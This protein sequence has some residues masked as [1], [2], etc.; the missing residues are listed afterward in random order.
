MLALALFTATALHP[1]RASHWQDIL[2]G[3]KVC[4]VDT[5]GAKGDGVT[6]DTAAIQSALNDCG[7]SGGGQVVLPASTGNGTY[8]S[9]ALSMNHS[10]VELNVPA[11]TVLR[12]SND[13]KHWPGSLNFITGHSAE[14]IAITGAGTI[15]GQGA[16]WW[17]N[18]ND[19][20]PHTVQFNHVTY[21][22][23]EGV[24]IVDP[25]NHCLELYAD[26]CEVSGV[27][28]QAPPSTG[29]AS[30]SHNTDAVDVHGDPFY[31]HDC[32][33][34]TGD[35]NIAA[36][37]NNTLVE[38]CRFGTGH[39]ASIGSLCDVW[40]TNITFRNISFDGTTSGA[41]IKVHDGCTRSSNTHY[42][43]SYNRP[44]QQGGRPA[45][46]SRATLTHTNRPLQQGGRPAAQSRATLT[47]TNR[48]LRHASRCT[49]AAR[50]ACGG[51]CSK[52]S[53]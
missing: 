7:G 34:N 4:S 25:P 39:G 24:T 8:L 46:Q 29:T 10:H 41:K 45:A 30:P 38:N 14:H 17:A 13:R 23:I 35:D 16:V 42:R 53:R 21:A 15:D 49:T 5:Y 52:T 20:R 26:H 37:A 1:L 40:L 12:I 47:H 6:D 9:K 2:I 43:F 22:L 19:F 36:H 31:V 28:I 32:Y 27:T 3:D 18:R 44:L 51:W 48:P 11:K 50:D 33:F